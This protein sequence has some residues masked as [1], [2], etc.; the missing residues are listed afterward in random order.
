M[1]NEIEKANSEM[2]DAAKNFN[3]A[4]WELS[5]VAKR[6]KKAS[7]AMSDFHD[8]EVLRF[9]E[10]MEVHGEM[11]A[12]IDSEEPSSPH[13]DSIA[14]RLAESALLVCGT[15]MEE[16]KIRVELGTAKAEFAKKEDAHT[17]ARDRLKKAVDRLT[18]LVKPKD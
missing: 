15:A 3:S 7:A 18:S 16:H 4:T 2:L 6:L 8:S 1:P 13:V 12:L 5:E 10:Y 17:V 14:K 11:K 9:K